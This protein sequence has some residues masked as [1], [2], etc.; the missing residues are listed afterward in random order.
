MNDICVQCGESKG[1]IRINGLFCMT[2]S[3]GES[4]EADN[5]SDRHRFKPYSDKELEAMHE[6]TLPIPE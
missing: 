6:P 1:A 3:G 4:P 5:E 2:M